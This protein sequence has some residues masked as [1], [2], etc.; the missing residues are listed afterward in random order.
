M[1]PLGRIT[2]LHRK[3][4]RL[5]FG[6]GSCLVESLALKRYLSK[7]NLHMPVVL[8]IKKEGGRLVAHAW[9]EGLYKENN[10]FTPIMNI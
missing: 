5:L 1:Q 4:S 3:M 9:I 8:G 6:S 7:H 2:G 10:D